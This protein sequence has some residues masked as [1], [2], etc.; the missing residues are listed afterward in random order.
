MPSTT[1]QTQTNLLKRSTL[2]H[3][4]S[5]SINPFFFLFF[6]FCSFSNFFIHSHERRFHTFTLSLTNFIHLTQGTMRPLPL[7]YIHNRLIHSLSCT[8]IR[9]TKHALYTHT[10]CEC[11]HPLMHFVC[12]QCEYKGKLSLSLAI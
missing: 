3:T 2:T 7:T 11:V 1:C 8:H 5:P 9:V 12:T 4:F 10:Y 6:F